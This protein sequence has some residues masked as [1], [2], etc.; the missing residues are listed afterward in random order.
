MFTIETQY[1]HFR[2]MLLPEDSSVIKK[3]IQS[4]YKKH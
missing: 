1:V 3:M 2:A 4:K